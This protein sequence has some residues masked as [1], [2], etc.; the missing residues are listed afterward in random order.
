MR[1][2]LW[3]LVIWV[4]EI[5]DRS[6][7][8]CRTWTSITRLPVER[9]VGRIERPRGHARFFENCIAARAGERRA[10]SR[11]ESALPANDSTYY[12]PKGTKMTDTPT[13]P[14]RRRRMP[15]SRWKATS[16]R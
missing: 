13:H 16:I 11:D 4:A 2:V 9:T 3:R 6:L 15:V 7:I 10:S 14:R 8:R 1:N 12:L 5:L